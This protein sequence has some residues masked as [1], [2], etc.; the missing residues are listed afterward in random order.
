MSTDQTFTDRVAAL[1][2]SMPGQWIDGEVLG[3][4]AGKYAWRSRVADARRAYGMRII[5]RQRTVETP[6]G[7]FRVSEYCYQP[8]A[9]PSLET[10]E[11]QPLPWE[12]A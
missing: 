10:A 1:F 12:A 9:A 3:K 4:V 8:E 11:D 5:N 7:S 6:I 2:K